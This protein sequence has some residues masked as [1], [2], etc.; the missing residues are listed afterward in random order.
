M[1]ASLVTTA[2]VTRN[3]EIRGVTPPHLLHFYGIWPRD[4]NSRAAAGTN[5]VFYLVWQPLLGQDLLWTSDRPDNGQTSVPRWN[6]NA[7]SQQATR[8]DTVFYSVWQP[9]VGQELFIHKQRFLW[10]SDQPKRWTFMVWWSSNPRSQGAN[11]HCDRY[12]ILFGV[13]AHGELRPSHSHTTPLD[14]WAR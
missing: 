8:T 6:S 9:I 11:G 10:T 4:L 12:C 13:T 5:D 2:V 3:G 7:W 14:E 1:V